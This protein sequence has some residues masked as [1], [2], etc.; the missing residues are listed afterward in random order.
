[1]K[2]RKSRWSVWSSVLRLTQLDLSFEKITL[3]AAR[4]KWM[5]KRGWGVGAE[6]ISSE[7][8]RAPCTGEGGDWTGVVYVNRRGWQDPGELKKTHW[9]F[10]ETS[11]VSSLG[12]GM[13]WERSAEEWSVWYAEHSTCSRGELR[14]TSLLAG[15]APSLLTVS[16]YTDPYWPLWRKAASGSNWYITRSLRDWLRQSSLPSKR[17]NSGWGCGGRLANAVRASLLGELKMRAWT[18]EDTGGR[19]GENF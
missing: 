12:T 13:T 3:A 18:K 16:R 10:M 5:Q 6:K 7:M 19:T 8:L 14:E 4:K 1:M 2:K 9:E 15:G 17:I 11:M